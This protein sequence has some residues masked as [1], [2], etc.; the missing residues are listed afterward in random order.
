LDTPVD[1]VEISN[2][3]QRSAVNFP[4]KDTWSYFGKNNRV[5][6]LDLVRDDGALAARLRLADTREV[7]RFNVTLPAGIYRAV[8]AD[9]YPGSRWNDTCLGEM[10]FFPG[11]AAG[12]DELNKDAFFRPFLKE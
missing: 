3:F 1:R 10:S 9:V 5:K 11:T 2:G 12:F 6:T 7:Q 4:D 8:I